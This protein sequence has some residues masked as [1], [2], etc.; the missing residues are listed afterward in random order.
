MIAIMI[1]L[2]SLPVRAQTKTGYAEWDSESKTLT[3]YGGDN[4]PE[5]AYSLDDYAP[6]WFNEDAG[7]KNNCKKVVF[8]KSFKDVR[9]IYCFSWFYGFSALETIESIENLNT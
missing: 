9:P 7:M 5:G 6:G 4:K 8:D 3:F 2:F 1:M